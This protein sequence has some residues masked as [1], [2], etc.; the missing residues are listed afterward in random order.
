MRAVYII[1]IVGDRTFSTLP[2]V[3]YGETSFEGMPEIK[4]FE[5]KGWPGW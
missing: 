2:S 1:L 3:L 4:V 5:D